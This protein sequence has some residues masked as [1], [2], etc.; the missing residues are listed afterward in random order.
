MRFMEV[1]ALGADK[2]SDDTG[3]SGYWGL[4]LKTG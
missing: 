4:H 3:I 1:L 2:V